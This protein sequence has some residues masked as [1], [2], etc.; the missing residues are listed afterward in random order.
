VSGY[1]FIRAAD[2]KIFNSEI[3]FTSPH[4]HVQMINKLILASM[5]LVITGQQILVDALLQQ[6]N[7]SSPLCFEPP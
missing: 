2:E 6:N 1:N 4:S 7:S 3:G 5:I